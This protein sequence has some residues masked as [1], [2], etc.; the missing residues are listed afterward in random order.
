M[1]KHPA[2]IRLSLE[3]RQQHHLLRHLHAYDSGVD[4]I[5]ND[6]LGFSKKG[7]LQNKFFELF[8]HDDFLTGSTGSRLISGHT[9]FKDETE[10]FI[11]K[12]HQAEA[13]LVFN[14]GYDANVGLLS[15]VPQRYDLILSDELIHAS[16][17]D[18]I[19]L[20]FATHYKFRHNDVTHLEELLNRHAN[21]FESVYVV[22]ESIYSM[23]GD[24]APLK[25][26]IALLERH[27][28]AFLIVD[29]AHAIGVLGK[30]GK[31]LCNELGIEEKC[32]ARV[33]TYGK[34]MGCHGAAVVGSKLLKD[35]LIN[36]ARSFIYT[37]ALPD[38][39][40]A[41]I[42]AGYALMKQPELQHTLNAN[43]AYFRH[44][45]PDSIRF[46]PSRSAIQCLLTQNAVQADRLQEKM[47]QHGI[48]CKA[49]KSPTVKAGA[50]RIRFCLH[51]FNT[52]EEMDKVM[53]VLQYD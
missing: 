47:M 51:A 23:D 8:G 32:F 13:A 43:I 16:V 19:R 17:H 49:V 38:A 41:K 46:I 6:Y 50:E 7:H 30:E 26:I 3:K 1:G 34:A 9:A 21:A 31:G 15:S 2:H 12:A 42:R 37:T 24:E 20:S 28:K 45:L 53:E 44:S 22:V 36:Y 40:F 52:K 35:Y 33:Y 27:D 29:E 5:S 10:D 39:S 14:S 25:E 18:G 48:L 4:F 11:A